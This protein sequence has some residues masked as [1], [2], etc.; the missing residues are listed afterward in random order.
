MQ[1]WNV[2]KAALIVILFVIV[3]FFMYLSYWGYSHMNAKWVEAKDIDKLAVNISKE[4]EDFPRLEEAIE[5]LGKTITLD[6]KELTDLRDLMKGNRYITYLGDYY[7]IDFYNENINVYDLENLCINISSEK[8]KKFPY[9]K[10]AI[11][12][13][14]GVKITYKEYNKIRNLYGG[15]IVKWQNKYYE[16]GIATA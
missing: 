8:M 3:G 6:E 1:K 10:E 13:Q 4:I 16:V 11:E 7:K 9:L 12:T 15:R 14:E 2:V 5:N